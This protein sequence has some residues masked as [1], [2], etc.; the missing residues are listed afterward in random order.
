MAE[1]R[2]LLSLP[3]DDEQRRR[4][5]FVRIAPV[6]EPDVRMLLRWRYPMLPW[7]LSDDAVNPQLDERDVA[8][9]LRPEYYYHAVWSQQGVMTG[10]CCYGA[11]ARINGGAYAENALDVGVG[12]HPD[13]VGRGFGTTLLEAVLA[14][15]NWHF[16]PERFRATINCANE[17]S[18]QLF[19]SAGFQQIE[20]FVR[21]GSALREEFVVVE[22]GVQR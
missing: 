20:R 1:V 3:D 4:T 9:L 18:L 16:R 12:M 13:L 17:R 14:F 8:W 11:D 6:T 2:S 21:K 19:H 7:M 10:Y 15:A 5:L 22:R